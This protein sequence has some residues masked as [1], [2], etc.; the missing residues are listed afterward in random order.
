MR[1]SETVKAESETVLLFEPDGSRIGGILQQ[2]YPAT[3]S[4]A[5]VKQAQLLFERCRPSLAVLAGE[6]ADIRGLAAHM[7]AL[8]RGVGIVAAGDF[9]SADVRVGCLMAGADACAPL[10]VEAEELL[11]ML[12]ALSRRGVSQAAAAPSSAADEGVGEAGQSTWTLR[13]Q[14]WELWSPDGVRIS[15]STQERIVLLRIW[16][17][18]VR[19]VS[20]ADLAGLLAGASEGAGRTQTSSRVVDILVSRLRNKGKRQG[21]EIP[22]RSVYGYGYAFAA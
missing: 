21:A 4:C 8:D 20:R 13:A 3:L 6:P 11:A 5:A 19:E 12:L 15:L 9:R 14:G 10:G 22:L 7:R 1:L 18:P 16:E 2:V 17:S